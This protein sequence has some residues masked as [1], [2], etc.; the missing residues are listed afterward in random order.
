MWGSAAGAAA[1][2][3]IEAAAAALAAFDEACEHVEP[4]WPETLCGPAVLVDPATRTAVANGP[5]PGG[6]FVHRHGAYVGEWPPEMPVAN[7]AVEWGG[8]WWAMVMLPLPDDP[9]TRLRLLAHESFHR[10][11]PALGHVVADPVAAHLDEKEGRV[12][13]RMELRALAEAL[14]GEGAE[15]R[16]A[17][18]DAMQFRKVRHHLFPEGTESERQ[19]E[20]HEGLAEYTGVRFSLEATGEE[21]ARAAEL[22]AGFERRPTYV[23][24]LGYGTGPALG[25]LLDRYVPGWLDDPGPTPDLAA[26]LESVLGP[27]PPPDADAARDRARAYGLEPVEA[28]E[29]ERADRIA[30]LRARYHLELVEGPV[31]DL[32]LPERRLMFNPN[33]VLSLGEEGNVYPGAILVGPWGRL[34]LDDG[35]ALAADDRSRARVRAPDVLEP[36]SDGV[37]EGPGW[38]LELE[39]GWRLA[40]GPRPGDVVVQAPPSPARPTA[41]TIARPC[42][43]PFSMKIRFAS[44]PAASTPAM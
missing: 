6:R 26:R 14:R 19:L 29:V 20:S 13:L 27:L 24:S 1:G 18:V 31:L 2:Q 7:T 40:P 22:V 43:R 3:D 25:L 5:D 36:D 41:S 10:I 42:Q 4:I 30:A 28:E 39:P 11:Q 35:G 16:T 38:T 32:E 44:C 21:I 37:V 15:A 34:T 12:W 8:T 9:L 17:A 33:T 23:R